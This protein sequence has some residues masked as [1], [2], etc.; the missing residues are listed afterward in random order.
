MFV[1]M[2]CHSVSSDDSRATVE[3]YL[4]WI[5]VLRKR[6]NNVDAIVLTEHRKFDNDFDYSALS[7]QYGVLVMKGSELDT[8]C[9]HF[10]VYGVNQQLRDAI[11]FSNVRMDPLELMEASSA[12]G[13][14]AIPAH[15]GRTG[16]GLCEFIE[17]GQTFNGL[18]IVETHNGGSRR[19]ENERAQELAQSGGLMGI[20][21]SDA[22][23]VSN[24]ATCL[25][26][27]PKEIANERQ[28]VEAILEGKFTAVRLEDTLLGSQE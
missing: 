2:H 1:D 18:S 8:A 11:D 23:L 26:S 4:K 9:G 10:L 28:L 20:G 17:Q 16:I 6:G 12:A 24:I 15:P 21:G 5:Q 27:F 25:T 22:H 3:G 14:V 19:G 13:A 7:S